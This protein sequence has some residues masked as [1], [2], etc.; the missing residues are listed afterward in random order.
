[1][2]NARLYAGVQQAVELR[3]EFLSIASHELRTPLSALELQAQSIQVQLGRKPLDVGRLEAK[4]A[5]MQRQVER[6]SRLINQML[7]VS[8]IQAGR[9]DLDLEE[10]DLTELVREVVGR[11]AGEIERDKITLDV[12]LDEAVVGRWDRLRIDQVVSNLLHNAMKYG[13]GAPIRVSLQQDDAGAVLTIEDHGIG[14]S[15]ADHLRIFQRFERA[16]SS[17]Q[18]GGMGVG[19]YIVAQVVAA[20]GGKVEVDSELGRGARFTARLPSIH[21]P[22][23]RGASTDMTPAAG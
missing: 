23:L 19:L 18:Y 3:D 15:A 10:M 1:M 11:F 4:A 17:R 14:I 6:L 21:R 7:D 22:E 20:H 5:V 12:A 13:Q 16:V 9:L 8:R 2:D